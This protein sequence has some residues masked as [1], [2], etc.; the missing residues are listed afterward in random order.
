MT[1]FGEQCLAF[2]PVDWLDWDLY[3]LQS[4]QLVHQQW[5]LQLLR[6]PQTEFLRQPGPSSRILLRLPRRSQRARPLDC[7]S[8]AVSLVRRVQMRRVMP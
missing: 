1:P 5:L 3:S 8:S 6:L 7:R 2:K 4:W